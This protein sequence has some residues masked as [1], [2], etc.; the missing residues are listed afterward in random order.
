MAVDVQAAAARY[1]HEDLARTVRRY[2]PRLSQEQAEDAVQEA[3][4]ALARKADGMTE[5]GNLIGWLLSAATMAARSEASRARYRREVVH[6][7]ALPNDGEFIAGTQDSLD[8]QV[9]FRLAVARAVTEAQRVSAANIVEGGNG[10]LYARGSSNGRGKYDEA[11]IERVRRLKAAGLTSAAVSRRTGVPASYVRRLARREVRVEGTDPGWTPER[12][13]EAFRAF[14]AEHGRTASIADARGNPALPSQPTVTRYLGSWSAGWRAAGFD[15]PTHPRWANDRGRWHAATVA[16]GLRLFHD[17][18]GHW[19]RKADLNK[20][21]AKSYPS[22]AT[23]LRFYPSLGE[24]VTAAK[25]GEAIDPLA[26][27]AA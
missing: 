10:R 7:N 24:A 11:T 21:G 18:R 5:D 25:G 8:D 26:R 17:R 3:W 15:V 20:T 13:V 4:I 12:I 23:V 6:L 19:P 27:L 22:Y 2:L 1:G 9:E 14:H 16:E